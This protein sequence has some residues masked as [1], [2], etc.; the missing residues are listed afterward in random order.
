MPVGV[1]VTLQL[2]LTTVL[3]EV[4]VEDTFLVGVEVGVAVVAVIRTEAEEEQ[5]LGR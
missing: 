2:T 3:L 4:A 1:G 5:P